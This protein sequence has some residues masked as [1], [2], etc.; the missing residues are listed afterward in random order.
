M[1]MFAGQHKYLILD[2]SFTEIFKSKNP[3]PFSNP[4]WRKKLEEIDTLLFLA[5]VII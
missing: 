5:H 4:P 1:Q 3:P 2:L